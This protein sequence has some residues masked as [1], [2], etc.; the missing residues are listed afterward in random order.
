MGVHGDESA[1]FTFEGSFGG[2]L[3]VKVY[4]ELEVLSGDGEFLPQLTDL[5]AV[6]V[7]DNVTGTV[8][9]T[10]EGVVGLLDT[11]FADDVAGIVEGRTWSC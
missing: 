9:A 8:F 5:F 1:G 11:G 6:G 3:E 10:E 2:H 7:D 4:G